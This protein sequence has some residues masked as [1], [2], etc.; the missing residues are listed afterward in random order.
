MGNLWIAQIYWNIYT[1]MIIIFPQICQTV[2]ELFPNRNNCPY[3]KTTIYAKNNQKRGHLYQKNPDMSVKVPWLRLK[4]AE[5]EK[6]ADTN[7]PVSAFC[8]NK[9]RWSDSG[10]RWSPPPPNRSSSPAFARVSRSMETTR[11]EADKWRR[12]QTHKRRTAKT[13]Q[14]PPG[15]ASLPLRQLLRYLP[16]FHFT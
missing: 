13:K 1:F 2:K 6:Q 4:W 10:K 11:V 7:L 14:L 3:I 8:V 12:P 9:R 5:N 15:C 16:F